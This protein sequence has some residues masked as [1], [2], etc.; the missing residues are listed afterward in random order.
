MQ[1][2]VPAT[3]DTQR[4]QMTSTTSAPLTGQEAI[5]VRTEN[6][7]Q[8]TEVLAGM[9]PHNR[10][11]VHPSILSP[12]VDSSEIYI[13]HSRFYWQ[14]SRVGSYF[15]YCLPSEPHPKIMTFIRLHFCPSVGPR[16]VHRIVGVSRLAAFLWKYER[17]R[18]ADDGRGNLCTLWRCL[19]FPAWLRRTL[20]GTSHFLCSDTQPVL[21]RDRKTRSR[22]NGDSLETV[23]RQPSPS[24]SPLFT[25]ISSLLIGLKQRECWKTKISLLLC[26]FFIMSSPLIADHP[27]LAGVG[28]RCVAGVSGS[29]RVILMPLFLSPPQLLSP[30]ALLASCSPSSSSSSWSTAWGRRTRAATTSE[31][32]NP[33]VRPIKRPRPRSFTRKPPLPT[34]PITRTTHSRCQLKTAVHDYST[35]TTKRAEYGKLA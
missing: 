11:E 35:H 4:S 31:R 5:E 1:A 14:T 10:Q 18:K 12:Q 20:I 15:P 22:T 21:A 7:F 27:G 13:H 19:T 25:F 32:E 33:P 26:S 6:L 24:F 9:Y 17:G 8:R 28:L 29:D 34:P 16:R 2:P 23:R 3:E 30:A